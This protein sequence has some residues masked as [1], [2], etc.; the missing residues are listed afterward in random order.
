[1]TGCAID[2]RRIGGVGHILRHVNGMAFAAVSGFYIRRM[3]LVALKALRFL[4]VN[5]VA[6]G[7]PERRMLA[8]VLAQL[9]DLFGVA[10]QAGFRQIRSES[11]LERRVRISMTG[12]TALCFEMRL[13][14]VTHVA[15]RDIVLRCGAMSGVAV[16]AG[17]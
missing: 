9:L 4:A 6:R 12:E 11:D 2:R 15:L 1:M 3:R 7:A 5:V 13:A 16:L 10:R 17:N 8:L 14:L